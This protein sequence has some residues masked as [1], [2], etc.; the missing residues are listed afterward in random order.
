MSEM[1]F[2]QADID[3]L[4]DARHPDPFACLGPHRL[5]NRRV[6]RALLPGAH[7]VQAVAL[8]GGRVLGELE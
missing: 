3:A 1:L 8:D 7:R 6:V 2:D 4:L 5:G